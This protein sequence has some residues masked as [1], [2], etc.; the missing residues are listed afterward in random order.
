M[1]Q[2]RLP[3]S[4]ARDIPRSGHGAD[5]FTDGFGAA[6]ILQCNSHTEKGLPKLIHGVLESFARHKL[7]GVGGA[8]LDFCAGLWIAA[9]ARFT[10]DHLEAPESRPG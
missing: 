6:G 3:N 7:G 2:P 5:G 8:D 9:C 1:R 4:H 10:F